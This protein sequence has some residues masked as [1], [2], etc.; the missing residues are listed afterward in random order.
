MEISNWQLDGAIPVE[1]FASAKAAAAGRMAFGTPTVK[2]P[3]GMK[4]VT[5]KKST[6]P[7]AT[8]PQ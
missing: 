5:M 2:L 4:P 8:K 6:R 7:A 1:T 3:P